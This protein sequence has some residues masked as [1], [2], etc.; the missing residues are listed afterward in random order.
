MILFESPILRLQ[1][2]PA[3][4][5]L[6]AD[7]TTQQEFYA[8][9]MIEF[10][11]I[12][13]QH[14]H[15]YDVKR[16]LMDSRKRILVVDEAQYMHLLSDFI[17]GLQT[18]RLQKLARLQTGNPSR[19]HVMKQVNQQEVRTFEVKTFMDEHQAVNWLVKEGDY[20]S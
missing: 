6:M 8:L 13:V 3:T 15:H 2:T 19:E 14:V 1:Y 5:I 4:D 9:E 17:R 10:F 11:R 12:V 18:T 16:L 20:V 7:L